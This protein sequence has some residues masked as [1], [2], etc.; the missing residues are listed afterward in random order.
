MNSKAF[1]LFLR[2]LRPSRMILLGG[3]LAAAVAA[4]KPGPA[5]RAPDS[6]AAREELQK[7]LE[8]ISQLREENAR[9]TEENAQLRRENQQLRRLLADKVEGGVP[10]IPATNSVGAL[11][12]DQ[13]KAQAQ[14]RLTHWF[15]TSSGQRHNSRCRYFK[16]TEGRLCGPDEGKRC[17]L[18]GG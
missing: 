6:Q 17:D 2:C 15:S 14:S 4:D 1:N 8:G 7:I 12:T 5:K 18:C 16:T 13:A 9:L 10:I 3:L 11:Q